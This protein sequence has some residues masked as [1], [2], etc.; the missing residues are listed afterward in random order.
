MRVYISGPMTGCAGFNFPAFEAAAVT[1][2]H[3]GH[4]VVSPH[5]V[6]HD[7]N[8]VPGSLPWAAYMRRDLQEM[9]TCEA[10]A[11][12]PGWAMSRG[13]RLEL[14]TAIGLEMR[15]YYLRAGELVDMNKGAA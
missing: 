3:Q 10:I 2:R 15:V 11:L 14:R 9:F 5:E 1:L 8:G 13:A 6:T 7:D 4:D 12:L